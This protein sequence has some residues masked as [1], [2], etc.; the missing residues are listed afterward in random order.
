MYH[1]PWWLTLAFGL[2]CIWSI[3]S[4]RWQ[5]VVNNRI[6]EEKWNQIFREAFA[7]PTQWKNK[8]Q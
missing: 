2:V 8:P 5:Y 6:I 3:I 4:W 1:R 7:K